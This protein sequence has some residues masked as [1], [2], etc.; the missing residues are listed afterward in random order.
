MVVIRFEIPG[1][2][3][4]KGRPRFARRGKHVTAYTPEKTASYENLVKMYAHEAM[5]GAPVMDGP[6]R[7]NLSLLVTPP[8]SW[9]EKKKRSALEGGIH[10]TSKPDIDN[11]VK[12]LMDACN[13]IVWLDDKQVTTLIV[14]KR[15]GPAS[16]TEVLV[17][18]E[19]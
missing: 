8:V 12:L 5:N 6:V 10:P 7:V 16:R 15:Y 19:L 14:S 2:P 18:E 9:S 17:T 1:V 11:T 13:D 3:V 4:G